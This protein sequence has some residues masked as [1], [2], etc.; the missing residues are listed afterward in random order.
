MPLARTAVTLT[1]CT[2]NRKV[3]ET[4][5]VLRYQALGKMCQKFDARCVLLCSRAFVCLIHLCATLL[6][7]PKRF[8]ALTL[9]PLLGY[10]L[11]LAHACA[12][13]HTGSTLLHLYPRFHT[14]VP[15]FLSLHPTAHPSSTLDTRTHTQLS[16]R[17]T[18]AALPRLL[19]ARAP[20]PLPL[21]PHAHRHT[22]THTCARAQG[23]LHR[24]PAE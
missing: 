13:F 21:P 1:P 11:N 22:L 24:A 18:H 8:P 20:S 19:R 7:I 14:F 10:K 12:L 5:R 23:G 3:V 2:P 6:L 4:A 15:P 16:H 9:T 17:R